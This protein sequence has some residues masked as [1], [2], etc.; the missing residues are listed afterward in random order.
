[1][2]CCLCFLFPRRK[3][4]NNITFETVCHNPA[5]PLYGLYL[6]DYNNT[7][8]IMK[9]KKAKDS[10]FFICSCSKEEECNDNIIFNPRKLDILSSVFVS[11]IAVHVWD[12]DVVVFIF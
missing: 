9:E 11:L 2:L 6:D 8:C 3:K 7:K 12:P 10:K 4:D 1:M 5:N